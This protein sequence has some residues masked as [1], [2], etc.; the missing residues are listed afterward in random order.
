MVPSTREGSREHLFA[1]SKLA[2]VGRYSVLASDCLLAAV[3][4]V[5]K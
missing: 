5:N 3:F 1:G 4:L 2:K